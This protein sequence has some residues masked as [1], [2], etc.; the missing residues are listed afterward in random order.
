VRRAGGVCLL[1]EWFEIIIHLSPTINQS[2]LFV[3]TRSVT[4]PITP[5]PLADRK[6]GPGIPRDPS[7]SWA[8][9]MSIIRT[10]IF[11]FLPKR[12]QFP[13]RNGTRQ[14]RRW[15]FFSV[16]F[17]SFGLGAFYVIGET[18][19]SSLMP[20]DDCHFNNVRRTQ[21]IKSCS[22]EVDK[23]AFANYREQKNDVTVK[24]LTVKS[25][26]STLTVGC[27]RPVP[28]QGN[29]RGGKRCGVFIAIPLKKSFFSFY[30]LGLILIFLSQPKSR[31]LDYRRPLFSIFV[32]GIGAKPLIDILFVKSTM[33]P[34]NDH[35]RC[36][37]IG[38]L[39]FFLL[40]IDIDKS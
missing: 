3:S 40:T 7:D 2:Q 9:P 13:W 17:F 22:Y 38:S 31:W 23:A 5:H 36:H 34:L 25:W 35:W 27:P 39:F 37:E 19:L 4:H 29:S 16:V 11:F 24:T 8:R 21:L 26:P 12:F 28:D 18:K 20:D 1:R 6:G 14:A 10:P 30:F 32:K 15:F 33:V